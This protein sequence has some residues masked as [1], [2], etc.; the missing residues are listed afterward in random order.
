MIRVIIFGGHCYGERVNYSLDDEQYEVI[1]YADNNNKLWGKNQNG[2]R[3]IAPMDIVN[4]KFDY[5]VIAYGMYEKEIRK[6]LVEELNIDNDKIVVFQPEYDQIKWQ[7]SRIA[8]LKRCIDILKERKI[9]GN[10]AE[11]GVYKGEFAK[12][13][14]VC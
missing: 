3:I 4:E 13:I 8:M 12:L 10:M 14:S 6:Q 5:I 9:E 11:L 7:E 2:V 1:A